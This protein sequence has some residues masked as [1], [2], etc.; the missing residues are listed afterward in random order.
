LQ[1]GWQ[2]W[3]AAALRKA[4]EGHMVQFDDEDEHYRQEGAHLWQVK[5]AGSR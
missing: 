5:E 2:A 3:Q 1:D 4:E